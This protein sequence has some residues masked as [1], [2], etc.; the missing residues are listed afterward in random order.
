MSEPCSGC[1]AEIGPTFEE[2][3]PA[4]ARLYD[5]FARALDP[6]SKSCDQAERQFNQTFTTNCRQPTNRSFRSSGAASFCGASAT[7]GRPTSRLR[8][9]C[10]RSGRTF[11]NLTAARAVDSPDLVKGSVL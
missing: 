11:L 9:E 2:Q 8:S 7:C 4:L 5:E 3:I 6:L 10:P 1:G